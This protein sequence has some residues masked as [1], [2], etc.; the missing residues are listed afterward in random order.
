MN[1]ALS[2]DAS[3]LRVK[4]GCCKDHSRKY[5]GAPSNASMPIQI[6]ID[7][8]E[9]TTIMVPYRMQ[10][11]WR[12]IM[13]TITLKNIPDPTYNTL[14]QLATE[15]HRSINSELIYLIEKATKSTKIDPDQHLVAARKFREKSKRYPVNDVMLA[16]MKNEGRP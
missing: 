5:K 11:L 12:V 1:A 3:M 10:S 6:A 16:E 13:A 15:H 7:T 9:K 2:G 4:T 14:K 8:T